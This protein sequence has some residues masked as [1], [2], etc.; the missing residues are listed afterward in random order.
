MVLRKFLPMLCQAIGKLIFMARSPAKIANTLPRFAHH[1]VAAVEHLFHHLSKRILNWHIL[2]HTLHSQCD[3][4]KPLQECI[5]QLARNTCPL[6]QP[7]LKADSEYL[8]ELMHSELVDHT[9]T[10]SEEHTS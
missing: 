8:C 7:F 3:P 1:F 9:D 10:R 2:G 4:L 6:C 5:V